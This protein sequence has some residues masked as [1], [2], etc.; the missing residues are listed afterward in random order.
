MCDF[1]GERLDISSAAKSM[2]SLSLCG[3]GRKRAIYLAQSVKDQG[4]DGMRRGS[5]LRASAILIGSE[6]SH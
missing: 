3:N 5:N 4:A 6:G 1:N 2:L